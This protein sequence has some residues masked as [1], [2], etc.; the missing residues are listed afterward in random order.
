MVE[1]LAETYAL[2]RELPR[3]RPQAHAE[4]LGDHRHPYL[5][6]GK[7]AQEVVFHHAPQAGCLAPLR[8]EIVRVRFQDM[9]QVTVRGNY[10]QLYNAFWKRPAVDGM[11]ELDRTSQ[12]AMDFP[13]LAVPS[14][15][16]GYTRRGEVAVRQLAQHSHQRQRDELGK[17]AAC[18]VKCEHWPVRQDRL[19]PE[20]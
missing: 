15:Y 12:N 5:T 1:D 13:Q 4:L 2:R 17:L 9:Q 20:P 7:Q 14:V 16:K 6:A 19:V 18:L 8:E 11:G 3:Q 10:R